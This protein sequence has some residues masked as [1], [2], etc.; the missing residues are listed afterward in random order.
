M[1]ALTADLRLDRDT[2]RADSITIAQPGG[3]LLAR[4]EYRPRGGLFSLTARGRNLLVQPIPA[5]GPGGGP[6]PLAAKL[7]IDFNGSGSLADPHGTGQLV[8][9]A[10]SWGD[11]AI[12]RVETDIRLANRA[13]HL[14]TR[15]PDAGTILMG[16]LNIQ[17]VREVRHPGDGR[18]WRPR[19]ARRAPDAGAAGPR[20]GQPVGRHPG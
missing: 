15:V 18:A 16:S 8:M 19:D 1:D 11:H 13:L 3:T 20:R 4:G 6:L 7:D 10:A 9:S 12:G 14:E 5:A 17:A 2:V